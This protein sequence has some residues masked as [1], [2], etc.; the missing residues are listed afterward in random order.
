MNPRVTRPLCNNF[1]PP[2]PMQMSAYFDDVTGF[3]DDQIMRYTINQYDIFIDRILARSKHAEI[4]ALLYELDSRMA[5]F[6]DKNGYFG[7]EEEYQDNKISAKKTVETIVYD[8]L[9]FKSA[10]VEDKVINEYKSLLEDFIL[11]GLNSKGKKALELTQFMED[12]AECKSTEDVAVLMGKTGS[13]AL[14][15]WTAKNWD[16]VFKKGAKFIGITPVVRNRIAKWVALRLAFAGAWGTRVAIVLRKLN[17]LSL[18]F[19]DGGL[20]SEFTMD[21]NHFLC[22]YARVSTTRRDIGRRGVCGISSIGFNSYLSTTHA[23]DHLRRSR[24]IIRAP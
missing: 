2:P 7:T 18:L 12:L 24:S 17:V 20:A 3:R 10:S 15:A 6:G 14:A 19:A 16:R 22:V 5:T 23:I 9:G 11:A 21:K 13:A 4:E 8:I 1:Q